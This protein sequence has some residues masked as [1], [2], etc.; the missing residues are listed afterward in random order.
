MVIQ[1]FLIRLNDNCIPLFSKTRVGRYLFRSTLW[2][3]ISSL[4]V[5]T[6]LLATRGNADM[7]EATRA[8]RALLT[9]LLPWLPTDAEV[10]EF[11]CG[12]GLNSLAIA[13]YCRNVI[14]LDISKGLLRL[15]RRMAKGID[16][17]GF[18][19]YDGTR[20]PFSSET[21]SFVFTV[22]VFERITKL[23]VQGYLAEIQ[24]VLKSHG[25][26]FLYFLSPRAKGTIFTARLGDES[27]VYFTE[28]EAEKRC[29]RAGMRV[30]KV[31]RWPMAEIVIAVK[32]PVIS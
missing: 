11:G 14:G 21:F 10:M 25:T 19:W 27:F 28:S 15:A 1:S 12:L 2:W 7:S 3:E 9:D 13:P 18:V 29:C 30:I 20:F 17:V 24:R 8:S 22:G 6:A 31:L 4:T 5:H 23:R 26:A 16:K 32:N